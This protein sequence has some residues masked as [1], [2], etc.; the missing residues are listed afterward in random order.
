MAVKKNNTLTIAIMLAGAGALVWWLVS[1]KSSG[2]GSG[3][4]QYTLAVNVYPTA[5]GTVTWTPRKSQ[6]TE[7]ESVV[8]QAT[9]KTGYRFD[10]WELD[11]QWLTDANPTNLTLMAN[12]TA[13]AVFE[14]TTA[15][16]G[17]YTLTFA[18]SP[19]VAGSITR[20]PY[21]PSYAQGTS[22][23]LQAVATAGYTFDHWEADGQWLTN[24]NP[25]SFVVMGNHAITAI[26]NPPPQYT[27]T[28]AIVGGEGSLTIT[29]NK[30]VFTQGEV[31]TLTAIPREGYYFDHW[32]VDGD[33]LTDASVTSMTILSA[34]R[35]VAVFGAL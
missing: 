14:V 20:A 10:H 13:T 8:L 6:Y 7:G 3:G 28:T 31:A 33:W 5:G 30:L 25:T 21:G 9:P 4:T 1:K 11:A 2:G 26:F 35:I 34:H 17:Q 15:P 19:S 23:T 32:E 18:V 24:S 22:V 12:H 16:P 29:P 27:L